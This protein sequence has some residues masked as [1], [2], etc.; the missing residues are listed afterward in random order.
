MVDGT[1]EICK[2][3]GNGCKSYTSVTAVAA[4]V[5]ALPAPKEL[6]LYG[7]LS[8]FQPLVDDVMRPRAQDG[9]TRPSARN[10]SI[11]LFLASVKALSSTWPES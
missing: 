9:K 3:S 11:C 4:S 2:P 5:S 8:G 10:S 7:I 6:A 1:A